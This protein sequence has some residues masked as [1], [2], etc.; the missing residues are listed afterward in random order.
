MTRHEF[1]ELLGF[2]ESA[3]ADVTNHCQYIRTGPRYDEDYKFERDLSPAAIAELR[4]QLE[5]S[6][7]DFKAIAD[8][9]DE[10][11]YG[12]KP[13]EKLMQPPVPENPTPF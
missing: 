1:F 11:L 6:L 12:R 13:L 7:N 9:L 3:A 2:V 5:R 8:L 4:V 10:V